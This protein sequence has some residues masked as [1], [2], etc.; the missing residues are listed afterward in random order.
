MNTEITNKSTE[1]KHVLSPV[2]FYEKQ[3]PDDANLIKGLQN[4]SFFSFTAMVQFTELYANY[5][6]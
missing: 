5:L 1:A 6:R 3:F 2:E 4:T